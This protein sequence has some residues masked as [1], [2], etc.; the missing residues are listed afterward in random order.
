MQFIPF[1]SFNHNHY[2]C[3]IQDHKKKHRA[4]ENKNY[5]GK[6][7]SKREENPTKSFAIFF[8][9]KTFTTDK[10]Q[11]TRGCSNPRRLAPKRGAHFSQEDVLAEI[12]KLVW[13]MWFHNGESSFTCIRLVLSTE[14][15][16]GSTRS[17]SSKSYYNYNYYYYYY[18]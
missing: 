9:R 14:V 15:S 4:Q 8:K 12:S 5:P 3:S 7:F 6:P 2:C 10:T 13:R 11:H 17:T 18:N 16:I 1:L